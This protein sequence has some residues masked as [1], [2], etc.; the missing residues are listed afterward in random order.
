M[1]AEIRVLPDPAGG[2]A[3]AFGPVKSV[4]AAE[5][6][7]PTEFL[8]NSWKPEYLERL[9]RAYWA[10]IE[11]FSLG[12]LKIRYAAFA[13][14]DAR[15]A[16]PAA[17]V[18]QARVRDPARPRPG[19]AGRSRRGCSSP[20]VAA[21]AASSGSRSGASSDRRCRPVARA[22]SSRPRSRTSIRAS[23]SAASSRASAPGSTTRPSSGSTCSSPMASSARSRTWTCPS[24]GSA[25]CATSTKPTRRAPGLPPATDGP[26]TPGPGEPVVPEPAGD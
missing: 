11:R 8:E 5:L 24:H 7:V 18:P 21:G 6:E 1:D 17:A 3:A 10:Y 23:A 15:G 19:H 14:R 12:L 13:Q 20:P 26:E 4:Q 9:A 16:D 2:P 25:R 22:C